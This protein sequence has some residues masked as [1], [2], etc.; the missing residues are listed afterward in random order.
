MKSVIKSKNRNKT[1][2]RV[3]MVAYAY[4]PRTWEGE[5]DTSRS[6][7]A[8]LTLWEDPVSKQNN[9]NTVINNFKTPVPLGYLNRVWFSHVNSH[10]IAHGTR[11]ISR[12]SLCLQDIFKRFCSEPLFCCLL[13]QFTDCHTVKPHRLKTI[14]YYRSEAWPGLPRWK[15][16]CREKQVCISFRSSGIDP[17]WTA[18]DVVRRIYLL[19]FGSLWSLS[20]HQ[21]QSKDM[22]HWPMPPFSL[23]KANNLGQGVCKN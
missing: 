18:F 19:C 3:D 5:E 23:C 13:Q 6:K 22:S 14:L 9:N 20:P 7:S 11:Y 1:L 8:W 21:C 16:W 12:F 15:F 17:H 10:V 2:P 4:N